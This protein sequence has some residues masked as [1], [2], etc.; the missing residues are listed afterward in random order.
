MSGQ[1]GKRTTAPAVPSDVSDDDEEGDDDEGDE[2]DDM[3]LQGDDEGE[4]LLYEEEGEPS[5]QLA[6]SKRKQSDDHPK[7]RK[8]KTS[9]SHSLGT[10]SPGNSDLDGWPSL[11]DDTEVG[12]DRGDPDKQPL[13]LIEALLPLRQ[14]DPSAPPHINNVIPTFR[15][16]PL[17]A[18]TANG[19]GDTWL[20]P[21]DGCLEKVYGASKDTS[22]AMIEEHYGTHALE[23]Q[24][25]IDVLRQEEGLSRLPVNHLI[26]KIRE[27]AER[28][29]N[30]L[31]SGRAAFP[32]PVETSGL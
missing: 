18:T 12:E 6:R 29:Q 3:E 20:C 1:A 16:T 27:A 19:P 13:E 30:P 24:K 32:V 4:N 9:R 22:Q 26:Q 31:L 8:R 2:D 28:K 17:P 15:K 5:E 10:V 14:K 25:Q 7:A 21:F 23:K 11:K